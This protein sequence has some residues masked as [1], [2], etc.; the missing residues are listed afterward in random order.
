MTRI[1]VHSQELLV[2]SRRFAWK[3]FAKYL[4]VLFDRRLSWN[5]QIQTTQRSSKKIWG[6]HANEAFALLSKKVRT[7]QNMKVQSHYQKLAESFHI[8][9]SVHPSQF[10]QIEQNLHE[11]PSGCSPNFLDSYIEFLKGLK[12]QWRRPPSSWHPTS[13]CLW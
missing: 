4:V 12:F 13:M 7:N 6:V 11:R 1:G 5:K 9:D 10:K 3:K 8:W 2:S